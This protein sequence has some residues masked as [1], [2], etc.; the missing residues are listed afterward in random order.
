MT[1]YLLYIINYLG[2]Q[3]LASPTFRVYDLSVVTR[4]TKPIRTLGG[5]AWELMYEVFKASKPYLEVVASSFDLTPQQ[6]FALRQLSQEAPVTMSALATMLGCDASNVTS[7]VDKLETRGFL[8]RRSVGHD[9]RVKSLVMTEAGIALKER[10]EER[11]QTPPPAIANLCE[12]D[13]RAL[14]GVFARALASVS[15]PL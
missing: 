2:S 13:Q 8:E 11:M 12:E 4:E 14:C 10:L 6:M 5:Q 3:Q 7:I 9:R 1:H 15:A